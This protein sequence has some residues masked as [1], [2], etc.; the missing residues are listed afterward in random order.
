VE[1]GIA[2]CI[3]SYETSR[4]IPPPAEPRRTRDDALKTN[5]NFKLHHIMLTTY[6]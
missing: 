2:S 6:T 3:A 4:E 1:T 5:L